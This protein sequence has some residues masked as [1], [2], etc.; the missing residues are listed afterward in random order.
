MG[1]YAYYTIKDTIKVPHD[2][3]IPWVTTPATDEES[4]LSRWNRWYDILKAADDS[5]ALANAIKQA[6]IIYALI[7]EEKT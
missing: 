1:N 5:P 2:E 3:Y 4:I 6:E 7:K